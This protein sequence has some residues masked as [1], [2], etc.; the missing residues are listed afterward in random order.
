MKFENITVNEL[1]S[2]MMLFS[3]IKETF[4]KQKPDYAPLFQSIY[5][6]LKDCV[7]KTDERGP[8]D[9]FCS[10]LELEDIDSEFLYK[11]IER[12][13]KEQKRHK[14]NRLYKNLDGFKNKIEPLLISR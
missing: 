5:E 7:K 1:V 14:K 13:S 8:I 2:C 10:P 6:K 9:D 4:P 12:Y 3:G 11:L